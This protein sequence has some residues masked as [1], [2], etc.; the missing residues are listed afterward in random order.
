MERRNFILTGTIASLSLGS[1]LTSSCKE[2]PSK[3]KQTAEIQ[4]QQDNFELNEVSIAGLQQKMKDKTHTSR[5]IAELYLKRIDAIDKN[6][7]PI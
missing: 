6:G 2:V 7:L 5:S 1:L 4:S 3:D